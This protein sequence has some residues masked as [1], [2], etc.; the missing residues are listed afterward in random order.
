MSPIV[1]RRVLAPDV[2]LLRV[3]HPKI[4][5]RQRPGQFVIIRVASGGERIPL[6]I[7]ASD[8]DTITLVVQAVGKTTQ[9]LTAMQQGDEITDVAGPLG[10]PSTIERFGT[11][12]VVGGGVGT[13]VAFPI[14]VALAEAGNCVHAVIGAR[15]RQHVLFESELSA[16]CD[17]VHVCTDDGSHGRRGLVTDALS[18]LLATTPADRVFTAGPV[19]MMR[20]VAA[21]TRPAGIPTVASL[22]PIMVDGTGM[23]GGCRVSVDGKPHFACLDGPEF[24][25]HR[26]DFDALANRNRGYVEWERGQRA[27]RPRCALETVVGGEP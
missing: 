5:D 26:V 20:A 8:E 9:L 11:V 23:C 6:T 27:Q 15:S 10:T 14:A 17:A 25:A 24:D 13:A 3:R 22:N 7:A 21:V 4:A 19:A 12:A 2:T 1:E 16:V 18:D